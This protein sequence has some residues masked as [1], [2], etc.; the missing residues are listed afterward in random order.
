MTE[1]KKNSSDKFR[2]GYVAIVGEPNVGKSTLMNALLEEKISIVTVKPQTTRRRILGILNGNRYQAIFLDTPGILKPKYLLQKAMLETVFSAIDDADLV[3]LMIE[4][5]HPDVEPGENGEQVLSSLKR[6]GKPLFLLINKIDLVP[7]PELLPIIDRYSKLSVFKEIIPI[8]ALNDENLDDLKA[9]LVHYLPVGEPYFP[10]DALTDQPERFFVAELIR[11]KVFEKYRDEIPYSTEVEVVEFKER[12]GRKD[13]IGAE[14]TVERNS[15]KGIL[16]GK[17]G[18]ALKEVGELA[19]KE[20]E[21]FLG[22]PV[23]L[24]MRVKVRQDWRRDERWL[25]RLG[26]GGR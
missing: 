6:A 26:Y 8:S 17:G 4:A 12:E 15:Q 3:F 11:E 24:E 19:R 23:F 1:E 21:K 5:A 18:A 10:Q 13:F 25:K 14:I 7:K 20:I 2:A 16:I 22:R 9:T